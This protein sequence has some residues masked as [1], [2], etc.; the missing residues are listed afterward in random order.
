MRSLSTFILIKIDMD[1]R[2][3]LFKDYVC[4][5]FS[6]CLLISVTNLQL[7]K[8]FTLIVQIE[9]MPTSSFC[10]IIACVEIRDNGLPKPLLY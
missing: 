10:G 2:L 3:T 6:G 8:Y 5:T 4:N 9:L 1:Y 7:A